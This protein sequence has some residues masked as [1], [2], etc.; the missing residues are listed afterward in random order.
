MPFQQYLYK[1]TLGSPGSAEARKAA[2][3]AVVH[4]LA[5]RDVAIQEKFGMQDWVVVL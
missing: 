1:T 4:S 3:N 2:Y 5:E